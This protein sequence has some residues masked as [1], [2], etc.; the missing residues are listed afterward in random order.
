[1]AKMAHDVERAR[2][3]DRMADLLYH[4]YRQAVVHPDRDPLGC[5]DGVSR[6]SFSPSLPGDDSVSPDDLARVIAACDRFEA[7]W[8]SG[9]QRRIEDELA[10][11][12]ED[13]IRARLFREL[14][15]LELKLTHRDGRS[16][17][18]NA[19]F[20]RF[21]DR[22]EAVRQVFA[23]ASTTVLF[24]GSATT[25]PDCARE[26]E[27]DTEPAASAEGYELLRE[28][29]SGGQAT[30]YLARDRALQRLVVLKRYHGVASA[31]RREAVLNEGRALARIR[32]PFVA[33]CHGV[34]ARS[35]AIDLVVEY[36]PGR[37]LSDLTADERADIRRSA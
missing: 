8:N 28:L 3:L 19:F 22:A 10:G 34:E 5:D 13:P 1:M 30:T 32:S 27:P 9:R 6:V 18:P 35:D 25:A 14:V 12:A 17:D 36:V 7:D 21:P 26:P 2:S 15:A 11:T 20:A 37:P 16:L 29:G 31:G 24:G 4:K 33:Q 23:G